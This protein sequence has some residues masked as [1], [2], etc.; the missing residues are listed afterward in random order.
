MLYRET[1]GAPGH[2][3]RGIG[4]ML[5]GGIEGMF[6]NAERYKLFT[7]HKSEKILYCI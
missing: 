2:R 1:H 5:M 6:E 7:G 3:D 4:K